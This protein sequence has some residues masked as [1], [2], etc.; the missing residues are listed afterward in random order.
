MPTPIK[1]QLSAQRFPHLLAHK[2]E[3]AGDVAGTWHVEPDHNPQAGEPAQVWIA[4][5]RRGGQIL[6]MQA[7]Q[8]QLSVYQE[9]F[10][11][12]DRPVLTPSLQAI[13]VEQYQNI[14]GADLTFPEAGAY[15]LQ[16]DCAPNPPET[17]AAFQMNY[18]VT[19][20]GGSVSA[21]VTPSPAPETAPEIRA[22]SVPFGAIALVLLAAGSVWVGLRLYRLRQPK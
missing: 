12:G 14:P 2:V 6:P 16:L 7:V 20:T 13:A 11:T 21:P 19:V 18:G 3:V 17:F 10:Q 5:T 22:G 4:L 9:P 1:P 8:C 15:R